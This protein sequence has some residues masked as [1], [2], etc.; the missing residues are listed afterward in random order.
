MNFSNHLNSWV[1][2]HCEYTER[3]SWTF[4]F[5][6]KAWK[7]ELQGEL[8]E[9]SKSTLGRGETTL[10]IHQRLVFPGPMSNFCGIWSEII[11]GLATFVWGNFSPECPSLWQPL[12]GSS[13]FPGSNQRGPGSRPKLLQPHHG[14]WA[15]RGFQRG[16]GSLASHIHSLI[17][18]RTGWQSCSSVSQRGFRKPL[19]FLQ[20]PFHQVKSEAAGYPQKNLENQHYM[21]KAEDRALRE[22]ADCHFVL[23]QLVCS[24]LRLLTLSFQAS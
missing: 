20:K 22:M 6:M 4:S 10:G 12:R 14:H 11:A 8:V 17:I 16:P 23:T 9:K 21:W 2:L 19:F 3:K 15:P 13:G 18:W 7:K 24:F 5:C 1:N